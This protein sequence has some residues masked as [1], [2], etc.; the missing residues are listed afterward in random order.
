MTES[1]F[2]S[3]HQFAKQISDSSFAFDY[4]GIQKA[5]QNMVISNELVD[6]SNKVSSED[7]LHGHSLRR[8]GGCKT[9]EWTG[10]TFE[11]ISCESICQARRQVELPIRPEESSAI[12]RQYS[13][14]VH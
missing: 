9:I 6:D 12:L 13:I 5:C 8:L 4:L 1:H 2:Q 7:S 14:V 10:I 11:V 3:P